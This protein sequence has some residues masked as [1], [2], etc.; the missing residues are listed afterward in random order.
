MVERQLHAGA[1]H[2]E[3]R[4]LRSSVDLWYSELGC[5]WGPGGHQNCRFAHHSARGADDVPLREEA[6]VQRVDGSYCRRFLCLKRPDARPYRQL[7]ALDGEL[8][9][10]LPAADFVGV[11]QSC[12]GGFLAGLCVVGLRLVG[13]DAFVCEADFHVRANGGCLLCL[14]FVR[15]TGATGRSRQ[16]H[17][18][19][20]GVGLF[21]GGYSVAAPDAR[22]PVGLGIFF[23]QLRGLAAGVFFEE[24]HLRAGSG[25]WLVRQYAAGFCGGS[26]T[27]LSRIGD[28]VR[29]RG[30]VLVVAQALGVA[31][32]A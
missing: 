18:G 32:D 12:R 5:L 27:V 14:A 11:P 26:R 22:V 8:L 25:Q 1:F 15:S 4:A 2:G 30:R 6:H 16:R 29:G 23:R 13:H 20:S 3:L 17:A 31:G 19:F 24:L 10:H 21:D 7:R 9:L 28:V